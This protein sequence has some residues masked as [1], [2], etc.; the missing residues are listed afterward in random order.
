MQNKLIPYIIIGILVIAGIAGASW[1]FVKQQATPAPVEQPP[2]VTPPE[3]QEKVPSEKAPADETANWKIY[4]NE[5]Y[6]FEIKYPPD[7]FYEEHEGVDS[8]YLFEVGFASKEWEGE[9][10]HNP[11][12]YLYVI[13]STNLS[14][15]EWLDKNGTPADVVDILKTEGKYRYFS[16]QNIKSDIV[17]NNPALRFNHWAVS[18]GGESIILKNK[19]DILYEIHRHNSGVGTF[20]KDIYDQM[21]ST[22]KFLE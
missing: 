7:F 19:S 11:A 17:N 8:D 5:Q 15:Q 1:Y 6:G 14:L 13:G 20:P 3:G 12:V 16:V 10:V 21:L 22:F 4:R 18:G 9:I 2:V